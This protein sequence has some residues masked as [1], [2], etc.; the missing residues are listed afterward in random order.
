MM[1]YIP[2][3]QKEFFG[4]FAP[5][6]ELIWGE[7]RDLSRAKSS[8]SLL[9]AQQECTRRWWVWRWLPFVEQVCVSGKLSFNAQRD[10]DADRIGLWIVTSAGRL[11]STYT[12]ITW[13]LRLINFVQ[14]RHS[15]PLFGMSAMMSEDDL[16]CLDLKDPEYDALLVYQLAHLSLRYQRFDSVSRNIYSSNEWILEY[17]PN[18]PMQYVIGLWVESVSGKH[19]IALRIQQLLWYRRWWLL[20]RCHK[21]LSLRSHVLM[22]KLDRTDCIMSST[23]VWSDERKKNVTTLKRKLL[24]KTSTS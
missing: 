11:W 15:R 2:P 6:K 8:D 16:W 10:D 9:A 17:L 5:K 22:I 4:Y 14:S 7:P 23:F 12:L 1:W 18:F 24:R 3:Y 21:S 13:T 19:V 20:E